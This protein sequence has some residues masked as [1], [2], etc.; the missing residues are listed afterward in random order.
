MKSKGSKDKGLGNVLDKTEPDVE[1]PVGGIEPVP[2]R[3]TQEPR[4]EVPGPASDHAS[5]VFFI[6]RS[7]TPF[8]H[9]AGYVIT[10]I[11]TDTTGILAPCAS[12]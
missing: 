10:T 9:I 12:K 7:R 1:V 8:P 6:E 11:R 3:C 5:L 2:A 4:F